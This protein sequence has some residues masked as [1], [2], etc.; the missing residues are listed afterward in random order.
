MQCANTFFLSGAAAVAVVVLTMTG[1]SRS[2]PEDSKA[3]KPASAHVTLAKGAG[4]WVVF[5]E[6]L[7]L[8]ALIDQTIEVPY[9]T[10]GAVVS[11]GSPAVVR[12]RLKLRPTPLSPNDR[13]GMQLVEVTAITAD[14]KEFT[15]SA[16]GHV[17]DNSDGLLGMRIEVARGGATGLAIP[18][19]ATGTVV[20]EQAVNL[21]LEQ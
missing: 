3:D 16:T 18:A 15:T 10:A 9:L 8:E 1:C 6:E 4:N 20:L 21:R 17:N 19:N 14:G 7:A 5:K 13:C 12:M 2:A 11:P